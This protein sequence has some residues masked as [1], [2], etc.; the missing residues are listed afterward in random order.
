MQLRPSR[1]QFH[2]TLAA[3]AFL[4]QNAKNPPNIV[5]LLSDDHSVPFLNC[6][7]YPIQTPN[8]DRLASEGVRF[9]RMFTTAPQC[10]PSRTSL[11]SGRS[12]VAARMGRFSSPLPPEVA[13]TSLPAMLRERGY[14]NAVWGRYYHLDGVEPAFTGP[15]MRRVLERNPAGHLKQFFD[16]VDRSNPRTAQAER[17][18]QMFDG[19]P[20][21]R[22]Y[23]AWINYS[24]PHHVWDKDASSPMPDPAKLPVPSFLPDL[25]GLRDD[26]ALHCGEIQRLDRDIQ[27]VLDIVERR[28]QRDNTVIVFMGDN[29]MA[30]PRGKGSL[31]DRGCNVPFM[32][33]WPGVAKPG[34]VSSTLLSGE[35][36]PVTLLDIA[37]AR[38]PKEMSGRSTAPLLRGEAYTPRDYVFSERLQHGNGVYPA[39]HNSAAFDLSRSVRSAEWKL[40]YNCTPHM[41]YQPVD[42]ARDSGWR[43]ILEAHDADRLDPRFDRLYFTNPRPVF[44]LYNL[45]SDPDEFDNLAG[46]PEQAAIEAS[47]KLA[48]SERMLQTWDFLP[49]PTEFR[50]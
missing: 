15:V 4:R 44:E 6:Y 47:L 25:P 12:P 10:V 30:F 45:R 13:A 33:R 8:L 23:F 48:L 40:I 37:G 16:F 7:G 41:R 3:P 19:I 42:S 5:F 11:M 29:G 20:K 34:A 26:L 27:L 21:D 24:D 32:V 31:Y 28:G 36:L 1:R 14:Y 9:D 35:D 38:V 46:R 22:P 50:T 49:L 43:Q 39:N 18:S 17:L 2:Q